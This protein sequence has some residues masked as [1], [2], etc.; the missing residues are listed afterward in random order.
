MKTATSPTSRL[1]MLSNPTASFTSLTRFCCRRCKL[2]QA[3]NRRRPVPPGRLLSFPVGDTDRLRDCLAQV[4]ETLALFRGR[5]DDGRIG[6]GPLLD[7]VRGLREQL[8]H[9]RWFDLV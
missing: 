9:S 6:G 2:G 7:L 5:G 4:I 8:G 1:P 3:V